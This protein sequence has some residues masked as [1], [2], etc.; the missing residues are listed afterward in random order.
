MAIRQY[1]TDDGYH[2]D[3]GLGIEFQLE[4][5]YFNS[6]GLEASTNDRV[7][8]FINVLESVTIAIS[9][10]I[11]VSVADAVG[12][13]DAVIVQ[14]PMQ[15]VVADADAASESVE[16]AF[17]PL[18]VV[19]HDDVPVA[20]GV[21]LAFVADVVVVVSDD[22]S[23]IEAV[24]V[25][26]PLA[27]VVADDTPTAELVNAAPSL[28]ISVFD[29][30]TFPPLE[31]PPMPATGI[32]RD[33]VDVEEGLEMGLGLPVLVADSLT[34]TE[35]VLIG[36]PLPVLVHDQLVPVDALDATFI[37]VQPLF[38]E[39]VDSVGPTDAV[40]MA[41]TVTVSVVDAIAAAEAAL[42]MIPM[43]VEAS[44]TGTPAEGVDVRTGALLVD[45][46]DVAAAV[47][48]AMGEFNVL[49]LEVMDL[50]E[51]ADVAGSLIPMTV[52][53]FDLPDG[54]E[55][56]A[57][58]ERRNVQTGDRDD[59][60]FIDDTGLVTTTSGDAVTQRRT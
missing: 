33:Y 20:E 19:V 26:L 30:N 31:P 45:V 18:L 39:A 5:A 48:A 46:A 17:N 14:I 37:T 28:E 51:L 42:A 57:I 9:S 44:E 27:V 7:S 12:E 16:L 34:P 22:E 11:N 52:L 15:V 36:L 21:A 25:Q 38:V 29:D 55:D 53:V 43:A 40:T 23:A 49:L 4:A 13:T 54:A 32:A 8:E 41:P 6:G 1:Q 50:L 3:S 2:N 47:D 58:G 60:H 24:T 35:A 10:G 59:L 56:V